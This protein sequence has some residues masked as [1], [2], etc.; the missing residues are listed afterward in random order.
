MRPIED[1]VEECGIGREHFEP[2]GRYMG[3][4]DHRYRGRKR[5]RLILVT[6]INPT[7]A[8]EGKTTTTIGLTQA[9]RRLGKDAA[10]AIREPSLGPCF[11]VKGGAT[12]GG[13]SMVEPSDRINL[14]FTGD[15]P[16]VSAAHNL[17]SALINN[18]MYHGNPL[19]MEPK[20]IMFPRTVDMNDRSLRSIIVGVGERASGVMAPDRFVITP[21]SE[22]MAILGLSTSI[23]ELKERLGRI[24]VYARGKKVVRASDLRAQGAMAALLRDAMDP[25]IVQTTEGAPA[26]VH[27]GPFGNIAH[28]TSSITA[29]LIGLSAFDYL[30][31]EAG[32]GSELG[33]EKFFDIVQAQGK[34][35]VNAVVIVATIRAL[36]HHGSGSIEKEDVDAVVRGSDNLLRHVEIVRSFGIDPVVAINLFPTDTERE[37]KALEE[38]LDSHSVRHARSDVYAKGGEGGIALAQEVLRSVGDYT[39]RR[40]Y[41]RNMDPREKIE[42]IA[43]KVYGAGRVTFTERALSDLRLVESTGM[44]DAYVCM[45]KT[46]YSLS[47]NPALLNA[48][49]GF[50]VRISSISLSAGA[51]FIVPMLGDIMTMPGLPK[52]PASEGIDVD[53]Q[54]NITGLS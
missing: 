33:G 53:E 5:G 47:D 26:F 29:D 13:R 35:S 18:H 7:P 32:F 10:C 36:K 38:I 16:A 17:L 52:V 8:G 27:T 54:G 11:G 30:V 15:F 31:T 45:A 12:G 14:L 48:P 20:G 40:A 46:Q 34:F 41:D 50:E 2:Y 23:G 22:V 4:V 37:L 39:I 49:R 25:N 3:K 1:I 43:T 42:A 44:S 28:G 9:L 21:A 24:V 6:G 19:G 51:G